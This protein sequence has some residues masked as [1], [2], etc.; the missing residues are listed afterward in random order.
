MAV[1]AD[2]A[3]FEV[4]EAGIKPNGN[5]VIYASNGTVLWDSGTYNNV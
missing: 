2:P 1:P 5:L 4:V 3:A